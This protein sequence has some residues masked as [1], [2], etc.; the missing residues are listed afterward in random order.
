MIKYA[1]TKY[2]WF[3]GIALLFMPYI[4][5]GQELKTISQQELQDKIHAYWLGQLLELTEKAVISN[6]GNISKKSNSTDYQILTTGW[7][8]KK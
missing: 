4:S 5:W 6:G 3:F 7:N 8:T 1:L 2:S